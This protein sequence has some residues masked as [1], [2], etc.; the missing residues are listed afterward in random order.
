MMRPRQF[1]ARDFVLQ[2][3][4]QRERM[5][6]VVYRQQVGVSGAIETIE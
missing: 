2:R 5:R 1:L 6:A 4:E 3:F